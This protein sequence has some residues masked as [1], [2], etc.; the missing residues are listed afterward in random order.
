MRPEGEASELSAMNL[1]QLEQACYNWL[2]GCC[3]LGGLHGGGVLWVLKSHPSEKKY[4]VPAKDL[5]C[6]AT[7]VL[8]HVA[9]PVHI[10]Q[11][12]TILLRQTSEVVQTTIEVSLLLVGSML[13]QV[14]RVYTRVVLFRSI[15]K[16]RA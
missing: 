5:V 7:H 6:R 2:I 12:S 14:T 16:L 15:D 11:S 10:T 13:A 8:T 1:I 9:G 4:T 3:M